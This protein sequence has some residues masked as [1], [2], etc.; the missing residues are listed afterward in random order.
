MKKIIQLAREIGHGGGGGVSVV[1]Q[2]LERSFS[3]LGVKAERFTLADVSCFHQDKVTL[4]ERN[5]IVKKLKLLFDVVIFSIWGGLVAKWRLKGDKGTA[6]IAHNDIM[7]GDIYIN[8]GLHI[9]MLMSSASPLKMLLRNPIHPFLIVREWLR[10]KFS[11][12]KAIVC[13]CA[14]DA[15]RLAKFYP[16]SRDKIH[17]IPNGI[18]LKKYAPDITKR[19]SV[20]S[21]LSLNNDDFVMIFVGHEFDRKGLKYIINALN[22]TTDDVKLL[23][24]G[25]G[26]FNSIEKYK[27]VA[28]DSNLSNRVFFLG[29]RTDVPDLL[30]A[31]DVFILPSRYETWALVG[32]EAMACGI[33]VLMKP[34]GG[35]SDYL[36]DGVNGFTIERSADDISKKISMMRNNRDLMD[37]MSRNARATAEKYSWEIIAKKYLALLDTIQEEKNA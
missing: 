12:H 22:K 2:E 8:H 29:V 33:P 6:T 15:E 26:D 14:S 13:F 34:T 31:S 24:V 3:S 21:E 37:S 19:V 27:K 32:L 1:A 30:N 4:A 11:V 23:V 9:D 36:S 7:Y 10:H 20:R 16:S 35:I 28:T 17:I 18:N 5:L 25:G